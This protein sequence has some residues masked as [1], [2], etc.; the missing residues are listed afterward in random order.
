[1]ARG[2]TSI[3]APRDLG[4]S[5]TLVLAAA[6][7]EPPSGHIQYIAEGSGAPVARAIG[8]DGR[9]DRSL[10]AGPHSYPYGVVNGAALI[11]REDDI[12]LAVPLQD[13]ASA[14]RSSDGPR[15]GAAHLRTIAGAD[16]V[17]WHPQPSP[18]GRWI[19]FESSRSSFRDLYK[20]PVRVGEVGGGDVVRLTDEPAG[21]FDPAWSADGARIA[22]ASSLAGQ[23]DIYVMNADGSARR[24]LTSHPGDSIRPRWV[25]QHI[26]FVSGRD[27]ADGLF[28]VPAAGGEVRRLDAAEGAVER[29]DIRQERIAYAARGNSGRGAVWTLTLSTPPRQLS[30]SG[31]D[32]SDPAWSPDGRHLAFANVRG[33]VP[34]VWRMRADG[35]NRTRLTADPKA[36]W[37]PRWIGT[38]PRTPTDALC[39][40]HEADRCSRRK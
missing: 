30:G 23:L 8:A 27:G 38:N 13:A 1:V 21:C 20:V 5:L 17:D 32:D 25:G 29:F 2:S 4:W 35:T 10:G 15:G 34:N 18:D 11:V 19:L 14:G 31:D 36:A 37:R 16:G 24:R 7:A 39:S 22:F 40:V 9:G 28:S 3:D 33:G 6:C 26:V 12:A